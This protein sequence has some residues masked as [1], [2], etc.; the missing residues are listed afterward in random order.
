MTE[1]FKT[2]MTRRNR[3]VRFAGLLVLSAVLA[4]LQVASLPVAEA[5]SPA[6]YSLRFFGNGSAA[7]G[8]DRVK[9][10]ID[11]PSNSLS[12]PPADVGAT[13]F[14]IEF[15]IKGFAAENTSAPQTCGANVNWIYGNIV[16]DRDRYNQDRK[17]G[18]SIAGGKPIFGVSGDGTGDRTIC[19]TA[20]VLDGSWHHVA[21]ARRRSDGWMWLFVDG[22]L[23]AQADGPDGDVSYPDDGVPG[24]FCGGPCTDSDPF[25]VLG[26][27]KHDAGLAYPSFSGW[28]D[29]VRIST[30]LRYTA[31]FAPPT[32]PFTA[33]AATAALYHFDEG[34]GNVAHDSSGA[35]GG[36]SDG[37]LEL[38]GSPAGPKWSTDTPFG[39]AGKCNSRP[40][41]PASVQYFAEGATRDFFDTW[42]LLANPGT[43]P[44]TACLTFLT[45]G[46]VVPGPEVIV[47]P[48]RRRSVRVDDHVDT[49]DVA[50][51][52][53]GV[54]G[55]VYA[56][57]AMYSTKPGMQGAHLS[58]GSA[59]AA[60][61]WFMAEGAAAGEFETWILLAN[62]GSSAAATVNVE[63]LT[64][65]GPVT[66]PPVTLEPLRRR[67]IRVND[68]VST[69]QVAT[70]VYSTGTKV[71]AERATYAAGGT[72]KGATA[73]PGVSSP[74]NQ[75][76]LAEGATT[77]P[78]ETWI[79]VANP[80]MTQ[81]ADVQVAFLGPSGPEATAPLTVPP[82]SRR[83]VRA[84]DY[85]DSY[86][87][88]TMVSSAGVPVVAERAMYRYTGPGSVGAA[89]GEPT[90]SVGSSWLAVEGASAGGFETWILVANPHPS[91]SATVELT[92][93][94]EAGAVT[95]PS[96]VIP[97]SSRRSFRVNSTVET[98]DVATLVTVGSGPGVVV[99]RAVYAPAWLTGDSSAGPAI[100]LS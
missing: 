36:P 44:V 30:T 77:D 12:G 82:G 45:A 38:G 1:D 80:S 7:P 43:Q 98:Y 86:D 49:F 72:R 28:M 48:G 91:S 13:D 40:T 17:F 68:Y 37:T 19:A 95:G 33:D 97:P 26:A 66:V 46:S 15:W 65:S 63:F 4:T 96:A 84:D 70:R 47:P 9:I 89:S 14:T 55:P 34:S 8:K 53:E 25:I 75:L 57:R 60:G 79:L 10:R 100:R 20:T 22:G 81:E 52:V 27:E 31:P 74:S 50:T 78:F 5:A 76:F 85:V 54:D 21:V 67:S 42:I 71:V 61:A 90:E 62:P 99:E 94:T 56:E 39:T 64:E 59:G 73:S 32:A 87:V 29:E 16:F 58:R 41:A 23:Q 18:I 35:P 3:L 83:T 92:Y 11:D 6:G 69:Y 24:N 51:I 2:G 88:S 93:L